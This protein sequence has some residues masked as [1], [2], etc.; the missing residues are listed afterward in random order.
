MERNA[1]PIYLST[2]SSVF[3]SLARVAA[4]LSGLC[5]LGC[6]AFA[7][8]SPGPLS[9]AH[10]QLEGVTKCSTCHDFGAGDRRLK[11]LECH[12]EIQRRIA[13]HTGY[14][15]KAYNVSPTEID[16]A[17]CHLEHNGQKFPLT[18][19]DRKIP[20]ETSALVIYRI[21]TSATASV[22]LLA[23]PPPALA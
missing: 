12:A 2:L 21:W 7:Q 10:Q 14:H 3:I 6:V 17:R 8:I 18:R 11:C 13:A 19:L 4:L 15:A 5:G 22:P 1:S 20:K 23:A 16:C 9:R